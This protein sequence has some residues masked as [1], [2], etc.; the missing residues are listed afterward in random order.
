MTSYS[1]YDDV[2]MRWVTVCRIS[3]LMAN[4]VLYLWRFCKRIRLYKIKKKSLRSVLV[5][6]VT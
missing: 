4:N 5:Y 6:L 2:W 1:L 3:E